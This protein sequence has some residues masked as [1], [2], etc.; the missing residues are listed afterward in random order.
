MTKTADVDKALSD[1]RVELINTLMKFP[2]FNSRHE[3][4]AIILEELDELWELVKK[5]SDDNIQDEMYK[6]ANQVAAMAVRFMLEMKNMKPVP[7]H[8]A[9]P[10]ESSLPPWVTGVMF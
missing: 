8:V 1:V 10:R 2:P 6:E 5:K 7:Q 3:G 4:Y 9:T